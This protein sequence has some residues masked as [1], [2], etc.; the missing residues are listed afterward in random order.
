MSE[1]AAWPAQSGHQ[2]DPPEHVA[3]PGPDE[4]RGPRIGPADTR[5]PS[6]GRDEGVEKPDDGPPR[7]EPG[8]P[9]RDATSLSVQ[10]HAEEL[11]F[12][13]RAHADALAA[14]AQAEAEELL[15]RAHAQAEVLRVRAEAM[16]AEAEYMRSEAGAVAAAVKE[17]IEAASSCAE[18]AAAEARAA[19]EEVRSAMRLEAAAARQDL[20]QMKAAAISIRRSLRAEIDAGLADSERLRAEVRRLCADTNKLAAELGLLLAAA[21]AADDRIGDDVDAG[22]VDE[23]PSAESHGTRGV[24]S[25]E[26]SIASPSAPGGTAG[27]LTGAAPPPSDTNVAELLRQL[28]HAA[29]ANQSTAMGA[30]EEAEG[31]TAPLGGLHAAQPL[32]GSGGWWAKE[33]VAP[34]VGGR[35]GDA[36]AP[37]PPGRRRRRFHRG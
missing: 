32:I 12:R 33:T 8:R 25:Y 15:S 10:R 7:G 11:V 35:T 5:A 36:P 30:P 19:A 1:S 4:V 37:P 16:R 21:G 6:F 22:P 27:R 31:P 28:L 20:E 18:S 23:W 24:E 17:E 14:Q 3:R 9:L 29:A 34:D 2:G 13:T 26:G